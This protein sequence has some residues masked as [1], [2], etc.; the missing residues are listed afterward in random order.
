[1]NRRKRETPKHHRRIEKE[2]TK[3]PA[4]DENLFCIFPVL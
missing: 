2:K 4:L 3:L 1:M